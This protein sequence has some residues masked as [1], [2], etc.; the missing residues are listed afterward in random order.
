MGEFGSKYT[1]S[2]PINECRQKPVF[3]YFWTTPKE[4]AIVQHAVD[5]INPKQKEKLGVKDETY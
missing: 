5:D 4:N 2:R 1:K 3:K